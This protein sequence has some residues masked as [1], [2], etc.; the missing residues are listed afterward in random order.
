MVFDLF[1]GRILGDYYLN[2]KVDDLER[3][4]GFLGRCLMFH[5]EEKRTM[6]DKRM[7]ARFKSMVTCPRYV[8]EEKYMPK[9]MVD[10]HVNLTGSTND[11]DCAELE[12]DDRRQVPIAVSE[13]RKARTAENKAYFDRLLAVKPEE[14]HAAL[15]EF[16]LSDFNPRDIPKT[17]TMRLQK[18]RHLP[19]PLKW[20]YE[21]IVNAGA[22]IFEY[23]LRPK[24]DVYAS[25]VEW[26]GSD[27]HHR[28]STPV[29]FWSLI[30]TVLGDALY[31]EHRPS[32]SDR[33]RVWNAP[34]PDD[35]RQ[36]FCHYMDDKGFFTS[37]LL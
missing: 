10:N 25:Y 28:P 24:A 31:E 22:F 12:H 2:G 19:S 9:A 32:G 1:L 18:L 27:T 15:L 3:F 33:A 17:R 7:L 35:A 21:Q 8:L 29:E 14:V 26:V 11:D 37:R 6:A 13:H 30:R 5:L 16:D 34:A 23:P 36:A 4:L 20:W